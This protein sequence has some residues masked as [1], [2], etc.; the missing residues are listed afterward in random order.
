MKLI[1][2]KEMIGTNVLTPDGTTIGMIKDFVFSADFKTVVQVDAGDRH[3]QL[4]ALALDTENECFV[5]VGE[6]ARPEPQG[7]PRASVSR[8]ARPSPA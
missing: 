5:L 1:W 6:N 2:A 8:S 4:T 7:T 3:L